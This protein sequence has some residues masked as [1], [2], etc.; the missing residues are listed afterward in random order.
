MSRMLQFA[1]P[2]SLLF[3]SLC[4]AQTASI[5]GD[6]KGEDGKPLAGAV[7]KIE[8]TDIKQNYS[9]K[10]DKK[11]HYFYGGLGFPGTFNVTIEVNGKVA[12]SVQGVKPSP[13]S[14]VN[15][16]LKAAA[17]RAAKPATPAE[18]ERGMTPAQKADYEKKKKDAEAE[19]AKNKELNDA[20]NAGMEADTN[21]NY[22]VAIQQFKKA[23]ELGPT[24]PVVWSHLADEHGLRSDKE[25]GDAKQADLDEAITDY[26][27]AI[28]LDAN[29]AAYHNNYALIL[30]KDKK[31]DEGGAEL[32][33]A[34]AMDP[35][36]AGKYYYNLGAVLANV[37]QND[38]AG[39]AFK[40]SMAAGYA[41]AYYQYGLT[42]VAKATTAADGKIVAPDGTVQA[43]QKYL[44]VAPTGPNA[45]GAKDML[46]ALGAGIE[47]SFDKPGSKN[48]NKKPH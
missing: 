11:G 36:S 14:D 31:L 6:V 17:E 35:S 10:T 41:E 44:E 22:D 43:F 40:K 45:Q 42:L 26:K 23:S 7:I 9:V 1:L 25:T 19:L 33:K 37:N 46:T 29:N 8:R 2:V 20:F 21:K 3:S 12:D 18:I 32:S 5:Q 27:K 24:Q 30:V 28:E 16:D 13:T 38:Q 47:T 34:A 15:F 39:E 48:N 4:L